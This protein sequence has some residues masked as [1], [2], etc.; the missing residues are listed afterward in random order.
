MVLTLSYVA[1]VFKKKLDSGGL[2][3]VNKIAGVLII[4]SGVAA[5]VSLI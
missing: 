2:R 4:L 5:L 1:T 3:L